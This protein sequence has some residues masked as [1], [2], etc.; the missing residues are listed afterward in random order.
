MQPIHQN[1]Q[2]ADTTDMLVNQRIPDP[3]PPIMTSIKSIQISTAGNECHHQSSMFDERKHGQVALHE[4]NFLTAAQTY[5][6][7][8]SAEIQ[9]Q[10]TDDGL[11]LSNV[12]A[13]NNTSSPCEDVTRETLVFGSRKNSVQSKGLE[14]EYLRWIDSQISFLDPSVMDETNGTQFSTGNLTSTCRLDVATLNSTERNDCGSCSITYNLLLSEEEPVFMEPDTSERMFLPPLITASP[15]Y[16]T[17]ADSL[18]WDALPVMPSGNIYDD[19]KTSKSCNEQDLSDVQDSIP[20]ACDLISLFE[21][22]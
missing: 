3:R 22:D 7:P 8:T 21:V 9:K 2:T 11:S 15:T 20:R 16:A 17:G 4:V 10:N 14:G 5:Q 19:T 13:C 1:M 18:E 12:I 6:V